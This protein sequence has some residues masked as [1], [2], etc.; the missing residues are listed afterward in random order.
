MAALSAVEIIDQEELAQMKSVLVT[1]FEPFGGET[2]NPSALAAQALQGR[3]VAGRRVVGTVLPCVFGKSLVTLRQEIHRAQPELVVCAGLAEGRGDISVERV[4][5]NI[6]DASIPDNAGNQPLNR[7]VVRG[8]PA[9]YWSTLPINAVVAALRKADLPAAVSQSAGT[10]VCNHVFYGLMRM[11]ARKRTVR[12]GFIHVPYLPEQAR[13]A[14]D[15]SPSLPLDEIVRGL[16]VA[17]ETSL[18]TQHDLRAVGGA[19]C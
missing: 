8:G 11:L 14:A 3:L 18:T 16:E 15:G 6:E 9:A 10:F 7:P 1:G 13:H 4:A 19:T 5:I 12:G 17:I 2:L